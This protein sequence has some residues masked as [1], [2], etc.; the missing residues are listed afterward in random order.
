MNSTAAAPLHVL[1]LL[2]KGL[3]GRGGIERL[4]Y[5]VN[6][7]RDSLEQHNVKLTYLA[8]RGD[9]DG[10][11]WVAALPFRLCLF[12]YYLVFGSVD[13][14]H[15]N[16]AVYGSAYRKLL[17]FQ[18]ARLFGKRT[19]IHMHGGGFDKIAESGGLHVKAT[20]YMFRKC[21]QLVVLGNFWKE[22]FIRTV[23]LAPE[24]VHV[25]ANGIP[26]FGAAFEVPRPQ[27]DKVRMLFAGLI[28]ERKGVDLLVDALGILHKDKRVDRPWHCEIAGSG[29]VK[30]YSDRANALDLAQNTSFPGWMDNETMKARMRQSDV[31]ILPSRGEG[32]PISLIE[33]ACS[34]LALIST[35]VAAIPDVC[36]D[37]VNG[38]L[39]EHD[40]AKIADAISTLFS[41]DE[42]RSQ[43]Q[44][45]SRRIYRE[46]FTL[47]AM[48]EKLAGIWRKSAE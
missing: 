29:E 3:E 25:V 22:L 36:V 15:I 32:L 48:I 12:A 41:D 43:M 6:Q 24:R 45:E 17:F 26:D 33:G 7:R 23:G 47:E 30:T 28:G 37:G 16:V 44:R 2:G 34:G 10:W 11:M 20:Y 39:V 8:T 9:A 14:V 40:P 4:F 21:S 27:N 42:K 13:V 5:Y 19:V 18:I 46:Q 35:R 38:L 1:C 31:L